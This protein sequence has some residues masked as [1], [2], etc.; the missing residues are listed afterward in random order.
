MDQI[1]IDLAEPPSYTA[2]SLPS[3]SLGVVSD[4]DLGYAVRDDL[5]TSVV[6]APASR[7]QC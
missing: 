6:S 1:V 2:V 5:I 7:E 3:A 4:V